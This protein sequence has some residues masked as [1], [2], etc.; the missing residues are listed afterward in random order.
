MEAAPAIRIRDVEKRYRGRKGVHALRGVSIDV[1][2]GEIFGLLGRNGAGK[3]TLVKILLDMVR[4]TRG[5]TAL[6]GVSSRDPRARIPIGYLPE[7]HRFPGYRTGEGAIHFYARLSGMSGEDRRRRVPELL[8]L[9]GLRDAARRKVRT[10]SKGMKQRL[11]LAQALAHDPRI[12]FLD[13]PT[14]GVDPVGRAEIRDIL[15]KLKRE[16]KTIFLNSHLLSEVEQVCDRVAI[17]EF[18]RVVREG[19]IEELTEGEGLVRIRTSPDPSPA[20]MEELEK[21]AISVQ[22]RDGELELTFEREEDIDRVVDLLRAR[23]LGIRSLVSKRHT[24]EEVF[25]QTLDVGSARGERAS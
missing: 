7:D 8:D 12:V 9:V 1:A 17:L 14:D 4:P 3:T 6:L 2:P 13:E 21:I 11:G 15:V 22:P 20:V 10:Y 5:E 23:S 16:R 19:T 24:L 25:I 18:G